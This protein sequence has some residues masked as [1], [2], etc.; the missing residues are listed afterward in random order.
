MK[1][2]MSLTLDCRMIHQLTVA[3]SLFI[4]TRGKGERYHPIVYKFEQ[5]P[6]PFKSD[7][8]RK[9]VFVLNIARLDSISRL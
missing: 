8:F 4:F 2:R 5:D 1:E 7:M 6:E 9:M 3:R